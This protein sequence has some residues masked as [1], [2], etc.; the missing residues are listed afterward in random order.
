MIRAKGQDVK[1][2]LHAAHRQL[3]APVVGGLQDERQRHF[4]DLGDLAAIRL[5]GRRRRDEADDWGNPIAGSDQIIVQ[6]ADDLD[7]GS[8]QPDFLFGFSERRLL[9]GPVAW[10]GAAAGKADL[11]GVARKPLGPVW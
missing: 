2:A 1:T 9:R 7:V 11:P 5:E 8:G 6:A 4:E 3:V 10:V